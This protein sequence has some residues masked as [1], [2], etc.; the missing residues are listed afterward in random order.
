MVILDTNPS[1]MR[2][3]PGG[4]LLLVSNR[5]PVTAVVDAA[6][7]RVEPSAGGLATG[8]RG[9][10][11]RSDSLWIGW[12]GDLPKLRARRRA[13]LDASLRSLRCVPIHLSRTEIRR[14]YDDV[15]NGVLWPLFHYMV[16]QMPNETRG[17][18]TYREVNQK[19]AD[20]VIELYKPGDL[21][22]V[23]DYQLMLLP[24][25][26]RT[27]LP[28]ANIGF[29]LHIPFPSSEV[30]SVLPWREEILE[31][32]MGSDLI[33][34]HTP[35]YLRH[36]ATSL[37]RVLGRDVDVD[38]VLVH[39]REVRLGVFPMGIDAHAWEERADTD[40]VV[41]RVEEIRRE[42]GDR[43]LLVG[44]DRLDYTKGIP[45]RLLAIERM[46]QLDP[47]LCERV[48][49]LQVTVPSREKIGP[50]AEFRRKIDELVGRINSTYGTPGWMPIHSMH[51]SLS[52]DEITA[53]YRAA[54]VMLVTPLRDGMNLVAKEFVATRTDRDGVLVLSE[55][56]GAASELGEALHVNP[57]DIDS[58]AARIRQALLMPEME[59]RSR[60]RALRLRVMS[61]DADRWSH[62]FIEA[63]KRNRREAQGRHF[64]PGE[65]VLEIARRLGGLEHLT[66]VLD[67]D[68]TLMPFTDTPDAAQPDDELMELLHALADRPGT[69]V[70]IV[71][72]RSR[73]S[74]DRWLGHMPLGLHAEHGL[75]SRI[76]LGEPWTLLR[77][78]QPRLKD[79][80]RPIFEHFTST[81]RGSFIEEKTASLA[82]HYR[83]ATAD[84]VEQSDFG[85]QQ[86]KELRLLLAELLSNEPMQVLSGAKV[87]EVRPM[88]VNKGVVVPLLMADASGQARTVAIGDDR[89]DEDLFAA[90]PASA[91]TIRVGDGPSIAQH[92]MV[93]VSDVRLFLREI[94]SVGQADRRAVEVDALLTG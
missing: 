31:G 24:Q 82:W 75:W 5:L 17:W 42:G 44:I 52:E 51:R 66:L 29:F 50:Y 63:M 34:F 58:M 49:L 7:V 9:P 84:F 20:A 92:R 91:I 35:P 89:T 40:A 78:V 13:E 87:V 56:A 72:G 14:F 67:Y 32:L 38:R 8:L 22:W 27:A 76:R 41:A 71:T 48:R 39:G 93:D 10:H 65:H 25:M 2:P 83:L 86:S 12:P 81:T 61:H 90:L 64:E 3:K 26:L 15:S 28:D 94:L 57:Y 23:H 18:D 79:K 68:G 6:G 88:G 55:F 70:H 11:Q 45:R 47:S 53:L 30:F 80:V 59:R 19:F 36:F 46:F 62:S 77:P 33:G 1:A 4:R 60:M 43:K 85:E 54:D 16:D 69:K 73:Q 74:M 21:I 37:R